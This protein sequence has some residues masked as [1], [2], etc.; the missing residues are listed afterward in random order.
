MTAEQWIMLIPIVAFERLLFAAGIT[1]SYVVVNTV[2]DKLTEKFDWK[3]PADV[4]QIDK[5]W[6]LPKRLLSK[7]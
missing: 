1:G 7:I 4:L 3:I 2:L 6:V 5:T